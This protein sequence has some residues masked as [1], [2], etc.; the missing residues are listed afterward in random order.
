MAKSR[1]LLSLLLQRER[2]REGDANEGGSNPAPAGSTETSEPAVRPSA[3]RP[4]AT[5]QRPA[6]PAESPARREVAPSAAPRVHVEPVRDEPITLSQIASSRVPSSDPVARLSLSPIM[7]FRMI[8]YPV[9]FVALI[10]VVIFA[11]NRVVGAS[12]DGSPQGGGTETPDPNRSRI[13][14]PITKN[15]PDAPNVNKDNEGAQPPEGAGGADAPG[16]VYV[17]RAISYSDTP[18]GVERASSTVSELR[19]HDFPDA[20][21]VR[22]PRDK[23]GTRFEIVVLAGRGSSPRDPSLVQ[24]RERLQA[25]PGFGP[26]QNRQRPFE[27][28]FI[29][30]QPDADRASHSR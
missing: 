18:D 8:A 4:V 29:V 19:T 2:A 13:E 12:R 28:S 10:A 23:D 7:I 25:L 30:R 5:R 22:I 14:K 20:R 26:G 15:S 3:P 6:T 16:Q 11:W 21:S 24:L 9:L 27:G 1:D 17:I